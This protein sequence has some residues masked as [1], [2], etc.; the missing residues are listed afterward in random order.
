M[1]KQSGSNGKS[2]TH[3]T[4]VG[5]PQCT[6]DLKW[7]SNRKNR[8]GFLSSFAASSWHRSSSSRMQQSRAFPLPRSPGGPGSRASETSRTSSQVNSATPKLEKQKAP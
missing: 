1:R 4:I 6:S 5:R 3:S 8:L 2:F 7:H